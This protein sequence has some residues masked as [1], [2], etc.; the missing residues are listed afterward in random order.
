MEN[1]V[2]KREIAGNKQFLLFSKCFLPYIALTFHFKCTLK[3]RLQFVSTRTSQKLCRL[4]II[5]IIMRKLN[6]YNPFCQSI[7]ML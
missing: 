5:S 7:S 6:R 2:R 4:V 3:C 1:I